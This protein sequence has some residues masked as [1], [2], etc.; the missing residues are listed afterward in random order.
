MENT[1]ITIVTISFNAQSTIEDTIKS[2]VNQTYSN[3]EYIIIDGYSKDNTVEII[4]KYYEK[5]SC[6][7]SEPDKGIYAAMNKGIMKAT[8][9]WILFMNS[10][11][12]FAHNNII[13]KIFTN[14]FPEYIYVLYGA[15][16]TKNGNIISN[17]IPPRPIR[18]LM[19][20][21]AFCHQSCFVKTSI[22]K[23][24]LFN[25]NY[26]IAADY[27]FFR[28]LYMKYGTNIFQ[29]IDISVSFFDISD[30]LSQSNVNLLR[31]EYCK[32]R[33]VKGII[34]WIGKKM[35]QYVHRFFNHK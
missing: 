7:V 13:K 1:K 3:I 2:V 29:A 5:V 23:E 4:K 11:D 6:W 31:R 26:K 34:Y 17:P 27:N 15:Y 8:G 19:Y 14:P 12:T 35:I 10:G 25:I 20:E 21:M 18:N 9:D 30:S 28:S 32:I 24:N 33:G 16:Q 22:M